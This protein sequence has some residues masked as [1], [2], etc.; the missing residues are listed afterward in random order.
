MNW[1]EHTGSTGEDLLYIF[2]GASVKENL[3]Q[4]DHTLFI[5]RVFM[6]HTGFLRNVQPFFVKVKVPFP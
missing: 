5:Y 4:I 6:L 1:R 3:L 2:Q